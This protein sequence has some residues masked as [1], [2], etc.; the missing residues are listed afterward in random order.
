MA[1]DAWVA[2]HLP[3]IGKLTRKGGYRRL[4]KAPLVRCK[5]GIGGLEGMVGRLMRGW[6]GAGC[7][8]CVGMKMKG[9]KEM[10]KYRPVLENKRSSL[11]TIILNSAASSHWTST[12][13]RIFHLSTS[14]CTLLLF[15]W[16]FIHPSTMTTMTSFVQD[17]G[18]GQTPTRLDD[19]TG[20]HKTLMS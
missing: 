14:S 12:S 3:S 17:Q 13:A 16:M 6:D 2:L 11:H 15:Q 8:R 20:H 19:I 10:H 9:K 7:R 4:R 5:R 1:Y 18:N